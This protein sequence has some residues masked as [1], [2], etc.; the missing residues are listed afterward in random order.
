MCTLGFPYPSNP[1]SFVVIV[2]LAHDVL[3]QKLY[4][5]IAP[6]VQSFRFAKIQQLFLTR[7]S[8]GIILSKAAF[9]LDARE[10]CPS[11]VLSGG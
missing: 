5:R 4:Q 1:A 2:T 3:G 6:N 10:R 9:T 11:T 8:S 7:G